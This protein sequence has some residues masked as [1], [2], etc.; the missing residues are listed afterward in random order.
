LRA[1]GLTAFCVKTLVLGYVLGSEGSYNFISDSGVQ[2]TGL[3]SCSAVRGWAEDLGLALDERRRRRRRRR[4]QPPAPTIVRKRIVEPNVTP[5]INPISTALVVLA[6]NCGANGGREL[7]LDSGMPPKAQAETLSQGLVLETFT[8]AH[9]GTRVSLVI[10]WG[11]V[12]T[13]RLWCN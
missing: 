13:G 10:V 3:S 8:N 12:E 1:A 4:Y 9:A 7:P 5:T 6:S 11:N 2:G